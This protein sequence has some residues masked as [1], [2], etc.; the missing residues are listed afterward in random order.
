MGTFVETAI[1]DYGLSF[2]KENKLPFFVSVYSKQRKFAVSV[3]RLIQTN[4]LFPS[5]PFSVCLKTW[6][7]GH[8]DMQM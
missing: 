5:V 7:H 6:I 4:R 8:A 3:F 1:V 2:S